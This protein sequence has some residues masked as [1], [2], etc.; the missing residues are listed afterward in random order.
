MTDCSLKTAAKS[1]GWQ[2]CLLTVVM[3]FFLHMTSPGQGQSNQKADSLQRVY[4]TQ[5]EDSSKVETLNLLFNAYLYND[6][7]KAKRY[8]LEQL[9]LS[10][11][12]NYKK[13]VA[14]GNNNLGVY[15]NNTVNL[16]SCHWY[17][18][19]ALAIYKELGLGDHVAKVNYGL[20]IVEY[21][22]GNFDIALS[23]LDTIVQLYR[24]E[25][26]DSV[27]LAVAYTLVGSVSLRKGNFQIA[28]SAVLK[29][30][31]ILEKH[32][33]V[34]RLADAY[35]QL[36]SVEATL[37][38]YNKSIEYNTKALRIYE[39]NNDKVFAAQALND[40]GLC[41]FYL[42][43][44]RSALEYLKKSIVLSRAMDQADLQA[45]SLTNIGKTYGALQ[46]FDSAVNY[47][48]DGLALAEKAKRTVKIIEGLNELGSLYLTMDR[49][50][51]AIGF[52]SR[53]I[54]IADSIDFKEGLLT[55]YLKRSASHALLNQ[56]LEAL[57]D[58]RKYATVSDSMFSES[59]SRQI[60]ELRTIFDTE[61]KEQEIA[62]Q[63]NRIGLLEQTA[64]VSRLQNMLLV[65]GLAFV[66]LAF[67][68]GINAMNQR[69][70]RNRLEKEKVDA[71]LIFKQ[72]ELTTHALHL[73]K[74]NETLEN[75]KLKAQALRTNDPSATGYRQLIRTINSD[76]QDDGNWENFVRFFEDVHKD[77]NSTVIKKYPEVTAH[78]IRLM[79]LIKMS[80]STKEIASILNIS[81]PGVKKARQRLRKKMNL[82]AD[83]SLENAILSL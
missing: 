3:F 35:S 83:E 60:E 42:K 40:I 14:Q 55:A 53:A 12:I 37:E 11:R 21:Y 17:Y 4:Q 10:R 46:Q 6:I 24:S 44:Y 62:L 32:T 76:L 2:S 45:S 34:I 8:A 29:A 18:R 79:A 31:G 38:N 47:L 61:K 28:L 68:A 22:R 58:H 49:P 9:A 80:L 54:P 77:F 59:K 23:I 26:K 63:K 64:K 1:P 67:G 78:E 69:M 65:F 19:K 52:F 30:V 27:G 48:S 33:D 36:G 16:D 66:V 71:E 5:Q 20:A 39:I 73:A 7:E 51:V 15:F 82:P 75:L 25:V 81:V 57:E 74:K 50:R 72:K 41:Y 56:Y 43:D 70:K 13:G